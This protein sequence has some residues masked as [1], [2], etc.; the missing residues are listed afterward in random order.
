MNRLTDL[1]PAVANAATLELEFAWFSQVL[2][3]RFAHYF[4]APGLPFVLAEPPDLRGERSAYASAVRE[5]AMTAE[6]RLVLA[7]CLIP[8]VRPQALDLFFTQNKVVG[9]RFTEFGGWRAQSHPGF[10]PTCETAAFLLAG[11][12]LQ[13]RF[14]AASLFDSSHWLIRRGVL[15]LEYASGSEPRLGAMP[16]LMPEYLQRFTSGVCHKPDYHSGFPAK[17]ITTGLCWDDLVLAP[18]V[19]Y[20]VEH[21]AL[22]LQRS[23]TLLRDW[24]LEKSVKPG[25][26]CLFY[27]PPGTGKTLT[28]TLLGG[29]AGVDVYR[30]DLSMVVSKYIGETE[31][32]LAN[33]FDQAQ[34]KKWILFFDEADALFGARTEGNTSNDRHA[35]QEIAYLLQ[36]VE[37]FPG[38]VI[39]ASN[40]KGNI[41][42]AFA[43]RFQSAVYFPMPDE[44][45][46]LALWRGMLRDPARLAPDVDLARLARDYELAGG[47]IANAVR[48][49]AICASRQGRAVVRHAELLQGVR[50]EMIKEGRTV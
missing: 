1:P 2:E 45:Q 27:G 43:R 31:K 49:A 10:L 39:L 44:D 23:D 24:G 29:A 18:D 12:D 19:R 34:D 32:N 40:L 42:Q 4:G 36:R 7:L 11:D 25:Y 8:H 9:Q 5:F 38:V 48:Y 28:A 26:R 6:E 20:E 14:Q 37:D 13:R 17:L 41:D 46:R 50:K 3:A 15:R 33:V 22:W 35:N 16:V 47:A 30:I 21:L